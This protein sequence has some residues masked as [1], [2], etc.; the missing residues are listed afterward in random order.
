MKQTYFLKNTYYNTNQENIT[1]LIDYLTLIGGKNL[2]LNCKR[3][4]IFKVKWTDKEFPLITRCHVQSSI[5]Y[6]KTFNDDFKEKQIK[7]VIADIA[8]IIKFLDKNENIDFILVS[9]NTLPSAIHFSFAENLFFNHQ[10]K[11]QNQNNYSTDLLTIYALRL[12]LENRIRGLLGIDFATSNGQNIGLSTLIKVAKSLKKVEY[13]MNVNWDE[14]EWVNHWLNHHMHRHIRP[15]PWIIFQ[16]IEI[17]KP[18]IDPKEPILINGKKTH[19]FYNATI[20]ENEFELQ[21]EIEYI[22]KEKYENII[23]NWKSKREVV[24]IINNNI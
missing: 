22:L 13:S 16:A 11:E 10:I 18:L 24:K 4:N 21:K 8:N 2:K 23:I 12:S 14:I 17:L 5:D 6:L 3:S 9:T 19:S 15:F 1:K 7:I 20:I